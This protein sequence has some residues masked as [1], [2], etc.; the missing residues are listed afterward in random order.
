MISKE[1]RQQSLGKMRD[2]VDKMESIDINSVFYIIDSIQKDDLRD[3]S[4]SRAEQ[5][6]KLNNMLLKMGMSFVGTYTLLYEFVQ[7]IHCLRED[8]TSKK[9]QGV[10]ETEHTE[11]IRQ[12]VNE[13][14][15]IFNLFREK[16]KV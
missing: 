8:A 14:L 15:E 2:L 11:S 7:L 13:A 16:A 5:V 4:S 6:R 1:N 9:Y 12:N 3:L 10:P